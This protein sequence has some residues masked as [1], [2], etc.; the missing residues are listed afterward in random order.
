MFDTT[1]M[2]VTRVTTT[3]FF[4]YERSINPSINGD[5]T[6]ITFQSNGNFFNQP[7]QFWTDEI[8]LYDTQTLT[9]TR[10]TYT[11]DNDYR[12]SNNPDISTDGRKIA[13]FS[14]SDFLN[15]GIPNYQSEIWLYDTAEMTLTRVT[16]STNS[17]SQ[18]PS[19]DG[20]GSEIT[21]LSRFDFFDRTTHQQN[22]V[23]LCHE[24]CFVPPPLYLPVVLKSYQPPRPPATFNLYLRTE[25][26]SVLAQVHN[27]YAQYQ[28]LD[29]WGY[30]SEW[31]Y[32]GKLLMDDDAARSYTLLTYFDN[33]SGC[34]SGFEAFSTVNIQPNQNFYYKI[35][36]R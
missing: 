20:D 6:K 14:N 11:S 19:I 35:P 28:N 15:Q 29:C 5:G 2:T 10:V 13:F 36:C 23:W 30:S 4:W 26:G 1:S 9:L 12:N 17:M 21:F 31:T 22:D 18:F 3:P 7:M 25:R 34:S 16:T 33:I 8:W 32:C 24:T 27:I